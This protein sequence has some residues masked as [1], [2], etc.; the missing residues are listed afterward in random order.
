M[1][2]STTRNSTLDI[3]VEIEGEYSY[4]TTAATNAALNWLN[5]NGYGNAAM[6]R[7]KA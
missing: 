1:G 6:N 3:Q 7:K 5:A 4:T 2:A